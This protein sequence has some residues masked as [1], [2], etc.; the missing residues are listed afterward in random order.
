MNATKDS[1]E[2][3]IVNVNDSDDGEH[4]RVFIG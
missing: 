1:N 2:P 4:V 3:F